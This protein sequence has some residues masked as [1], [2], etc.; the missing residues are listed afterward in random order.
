[1]TTVKSQ[2][3]EQEELQSSLLV[4]QNIKARYIDAIILVR[5]EEDYYTFDSD[6]AIVNTMMGTRV[7]Y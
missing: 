6:A 2:Q 4:W 5:K 3:Q 1:M 7:L